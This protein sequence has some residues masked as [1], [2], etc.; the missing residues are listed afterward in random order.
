MSTKKLNVLFL[1]TGNSARSQMA[2]AFLRR[3][4]GDRYEAFSAGLAPRPV[5]P[6]TVAA[7][8]EIGI[9]IRGQ[10]SKSVRE[11]MG[12]EAVHT[13]I[14]VCA[15][16]EESCPRIYPFALTAL[17]WP[18]EDPAVATGTEEEKLRKFR[19]VR[20]QIENKIREWLNSPNR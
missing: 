10:R 4:A 11:F 12:K 15:L 16:A 20:D 5:N 18:F 19:E 8:N 1:C 6:L 3:D 14:F 9:D 17:S 13:A 7:M 2:E